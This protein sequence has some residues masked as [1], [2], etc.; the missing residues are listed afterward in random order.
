MFEKSAKDTL[1][2]LSGQEE[3]EKEMISNLLHECL[4]CLE[5]GSA[6][7]LSAASPC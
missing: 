4:C 5:L 1:P 2:H 3:K 7:S 6:I